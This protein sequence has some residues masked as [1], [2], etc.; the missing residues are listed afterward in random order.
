MIV[1]IGHL[2][3]P[4]K[5]A[6]ILL[7]T[8]V[9]TESRDIWNSYQ[10][11]PPS[12][13][14]FAVFVHLS[15]TPKFLS[16]CELSYVGAAVLLSLSNVLN[17]S[18]SFSGVLATKGLMLELVTLG[19]RVPK[20]LFDISQKLVEMDHFIATS[21]LQSY[22]LRSGS[23]TGVDQYSATLSS[24]LVSDHVPS[25]KVQTLYAL[26]AAGTTLSKA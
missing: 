22:Y 13:L 2:A 3:F 4:M 10:S 26:V 24:Q 5:K 25:S 23:E 14:S 9:K 21:F 12:H 16:S 6:V 8:R 7:N 18:T 19:G 17:A 20:S 15:V 1:V 11:N